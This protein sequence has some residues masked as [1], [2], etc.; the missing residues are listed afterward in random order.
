MKKKKFPDDK[1]YLFEF[2]R[3]H[4]IMTLKKFEKFY[5]HVCDENMFCV[6][7]RNDRN[8][9]VSISR[10]A[11]FGMLTKYEKKGCYQMNDKYHEAA[12]ITNIKKLK[13]WKQN[14]N[15]ENF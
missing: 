12:V 15:V 14:A 1:D 3:E 11:R 8:I 13:T 6:Q 7:I 4:F 5:S 10:R 9:I 2:D